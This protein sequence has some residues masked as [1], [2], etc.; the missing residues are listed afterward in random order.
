MKIKGIFKNLANAKELSIQLQ[1]S[2][3]KII[4][5][6]DKAKKNKFKLSIQTPGKNEEQIGAI[7][8]VISDKNGN[9]ANFKSKGK[10]V[11]LS[12]NEQTFTFNL[13]F[14]KKKAKLKMKPDTEPAG[15][16]ETTWQLGD[17]RSL[18]TEG[19]SPHI[20]ASGSGY[21][22]AYPAA[23]LTKI[24]DLSSSFQ[25]LTFAPCY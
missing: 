25:K 15:K 20:E 18:K 5:K 22:L 2:D 13:N 24:D 4:G 7:N 10:S 11:D 17:I 12:P 3:G 6:T 23:G 1:T 16:P 9:E 8:V 19:V 21:K 14:S